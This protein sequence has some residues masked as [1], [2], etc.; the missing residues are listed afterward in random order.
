MINGNNEIINQNFTLE[1]DTLHAIILSIRKSLA[2]DQ[3][4]NGYIKNCP[5]HLFCVIVMLFNIALNCAIIA[6][7]WTIG[8]SKPLYK[9]KGNIDNVDNYRGITLLSC[10]G[11]LFTSLLTHDYMTLSDVNLLG[12]EQ[13]GFRKHYST[14]DHIFTLHFFSLHNKG[15]GTKG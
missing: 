11:K 2:I 9:N 4:S 3:I 14:M 12:E 7:D 15:R 10:L 5:T 8:L 6:T 13:A 1:E